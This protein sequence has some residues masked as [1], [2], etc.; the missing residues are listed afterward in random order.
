MAT[1]GI[2][3]ESTQC[4]ITSVRIRIYV[5]TSRMTDHE[6]TDIALAQTLRAKLCMCLHV[7]GT[8]RTEG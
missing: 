5:V 7:L 3:T 8:A 6:R 4:K 2:N 1:K